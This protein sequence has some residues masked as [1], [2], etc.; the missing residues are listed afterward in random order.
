MRAYKLLSRHDDIA[1]HIVGFHGS[2][3]QGDWYHI[4]LEY[5]EGNTL[6]EVFREEHPTSEDD[7]LKFWTNCIRILDPLLR[8]HYGGDPSSP[9]ELATGYVESTHSIFAPS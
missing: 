6:E 8:I 7:R 9:H 4:L 1:K 2:W 5:V 3:K